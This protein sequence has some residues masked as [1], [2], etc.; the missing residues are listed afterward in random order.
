MGLSTELS[1]CRSLALVWGVAPALADHAPTYETMLGR[2]RE[3][4]LARGVVQPGDRI[5]VTAGVPFEVTGTTNLL[6]IETI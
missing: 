4:L 2:A 1:T 3:T 6:K 5:V